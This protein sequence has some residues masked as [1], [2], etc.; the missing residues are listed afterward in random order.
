MTVNV[1]KVSDFGLSHVGWR[2]YNQ[3]KKRAM[4]QE[5]SWSGL[6]I[7]MSIAFFIVLASSICLNALYQSISKVHLSEGGVK[8]GIYQLEG[9]QS[10]SLEK[11]ID[12]DGLDKKKLENIVRSALI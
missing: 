10:N 2:Y 12:I 7:S 4:E 3:I 5:F 11:Y 9:A 1:N 8:N 6:F